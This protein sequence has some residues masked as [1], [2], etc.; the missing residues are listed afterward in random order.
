MSQPTAN[1]KR[2]LGNGLI[3]LLFAAVPAVLCQFWTSPPQSRSIH[4]EAF[5]YGKDPSV[6]RCNRGD[7][8]HLTFS[9]RDT[10]H[11]FFLEEFD[12]DAKISP[13]RREVRLFR[14]RHPEEP[15]I[16]TEEVVLQAEHPGWLRYLVSKSQ[17]RCHV[18]C[19]PM[20]AFEHGNLIIWPNT[21]LCA[22]LGLLV[23]IPLVGYWSLRPYLDG[24]MPVPLAEAGRRGWDIFRR[25]P[26]LKN[27]V[28]RRE[29]QYTLIL[30][31]MAALYMVILTSLFGTKVAGRN[32]GVMVTWVVWLFLLTVVITPLGGRAWCTVCPLPVV[33]ESLQRLAVFNVRPGSTAGSRNKYFGL[34][35]QWPRWLSN[36]WPRTFVF[37]V[38][39]TVSAA[40]VAVPRFTGWIIL[41][42]LLLSTVMA[43]VWRHRTFCSYLCPVTAF[44]SLYSK[45]AK[46]ALRAA[47]TDVCAKCKVHSC[48]KGSRKGWAC[49]Y[50][51]C[52]AE[53]NDNDSCGM[54][55][56]CVR[57]C[58]Y[59]NVTLQWRPFAEESAV[60]SAGQAWLAMGMLVLGSTYTL[61][62]LGHWPL[63][64]DCV[65]VIDK[66]NWHLFFLYAAVLWFVALI[67]LPALMLLAANVGRKAAGMK[68][69]AYSM[70][71]AST[72]ALVPVGLMLWIAFAIP[73]LLVNVSFVQQ[74]LSDPFGW[75]WDLL[76]TAGMT[77]RQVWPSAIPWLQAVCL[78]TG[79]GYGLRTA[80]R[81]WFD[82]TGEPNAALRGMLPMSFFLVAFTGY[83][84]WF[85]TN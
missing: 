59:E 41:G 53:I 5:R 42:L 78:L 55:F 29:V 64:R 26:W 9:T 36:D 57:T 74:S 80:W 16:L 76:G 7:T 35:L 6:I 3:L 51:L 39:G 19:G 60:R 81:I 23:G 66:Q 10:G 20:H 30:I 31:T 43:L 52:V 67:G 62:H 84:L 71:I 18:W 54:C 46:L 34:N 56:E 69:S 44:I 68:R 79:L 21:L 14:A 33:G 37:L 25:M 85:F 11:S 65:N 82:A 47:D 40:L 32:F 38:L 24:S 72:G 75:N 49:P 2:R 22:A 8:L 63:L 27:F 13:A 1:W 12:I 28:K 17:Y 77:W 61:I 15:S 70:M 73:M 58:P 45:P 50:E 83:F 4:V 48:L